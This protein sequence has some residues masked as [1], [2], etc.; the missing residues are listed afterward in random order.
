MSDHPIGFYA[1]YLQALADRRSEPA[2]DIADEVYWAQRRA[3]EAA[4][5]LSASHS[6]D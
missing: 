2:P 6:K 4:K 3:D 1:R 5:E